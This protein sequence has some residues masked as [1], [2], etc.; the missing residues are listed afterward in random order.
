MEME[1]ERERDLVRNTGRIAEC[2]RQ[3]SFVPLYQSQRLS[4]SCVMCAARVS[5]SPSPWADT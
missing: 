1:V 2:V 5:P 3:T 4:A